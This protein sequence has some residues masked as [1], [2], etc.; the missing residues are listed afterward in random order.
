MD[1]HKELSV[2]ILNFMPNLF[3]LRDVQVV[4]FIYKNSKKLYN[5]Q[6]RS[7][8]YAKTQSRTH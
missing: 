1:V 3:N 4:I 2:T 7:S 8:L 5:I 6:G